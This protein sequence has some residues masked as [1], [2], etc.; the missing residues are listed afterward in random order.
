[1]SVSGPSLI[2]APTHSSAQA[3]FSAGDEHFIASISS[4]P[5]QADPPSEH[6]EGSTFSPWGIAVGGAGL[7]LTVLCRKPPE[8]GPAPFCPYLPTGCSLPSSLGH[9]GAA[10]GFMMPEGPQLWV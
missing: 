3:S 2:P 6:F 10:Q 7:T 5:A 9:L 1:M 4:P 8:G